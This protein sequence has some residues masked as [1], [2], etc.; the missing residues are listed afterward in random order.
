MET[1]TL[2]IPMSKSISPSPPPVIRKN[3]FASA[4]FRASRERDAVP[5]EVIVVS[6]EHSVA[7]E[8]EN[9]EEECGDWR[10]KGI[11]YSALEGCVGWRHF[12]GFCKRCRAWWCHFVAQVEARYLTLL[13]S[14]LKICKLMRH[15]LSRFVGKKASWLRKWID[16]K[17]MK[18]QSSLLRTGRAT[19]TRSAEFDELI[20]NILT[21][22]EPCRT[23]CTWPK[24]QQSQHNIMLLVFWTI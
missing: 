5:F 9:V 16:C 12:P 8:I 20:A 10:K 19:K 15:V 23:A 24:S 7:K 18:K 2:W 11:D 17:I 22:Q 6:V 14:Q 4:W 3:I 21:K 13:W 1:L